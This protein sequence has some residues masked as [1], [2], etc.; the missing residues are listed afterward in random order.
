MAN[1]LGKS[2]CIIDIF[3]FCS[4][5]FL[6]LSALFY[7]TQIS[8]E[9]WKYSFFPVEKKFFSSFSLWQETTG[10]SPSILG[11]HLWLSSAYSCR[12]RTT[13]WGA[14]KG[15]YYLDNFYIWKPLSV[16][17]GSGIFW[18]GSIRNTELILLRQSVG[19]LPDIR[20]LISCF[21]VSCLRR[22]TL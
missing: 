19:L 16:S 9:V 5:T 12:Q 22:V 13:G 15:V 3:W 10:P 11:I 7:L 8:V 18:Q 20:R 14:K 17:Y 4:L 2:Q 6:L 21:L 1:A